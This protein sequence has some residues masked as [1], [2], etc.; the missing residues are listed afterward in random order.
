MSPRSASPKP[1]PRRHPQAPRRD[2]NPG[3]DGEAIGHIFDQLGFQFPPSSTKSGVPNSPMPPAIASSMNPRGHLRR[4]EGPPAWIE[5]PG[6]NSAF[7]PVNS[8]LS[9]TAG[10]STSGARRRAA[11]RE[12]SLLRKFPLLGA[13]PSPG[14]SDTLSVRH[15]PWAEVKCAAHPSP[16]FCLHRCR[17]LSSV[18]APSRRRR[19][20]LWLAFSARSSA[21]SRA[22]W[23][24]VIHQCAQICVPRN[25]PATLRASLP[26]LVRCPLEHSLTALTPPSTDFLQPA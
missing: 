18:F 21:S 15:I 6:P 8:S 16:V 25:S 19:T 20:A 22:L 2:R 1:R 26:P 24:A 17:V 9:A 10:C 14:L 5:Q 3:E 12:T 11:P 13:D 23:S 4:L 7:T